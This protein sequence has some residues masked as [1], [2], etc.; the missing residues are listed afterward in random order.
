MQAAEPWGGG[1]LY[2]TPAGLPGRSAWVPPPPACWGLRSATAPPSP[3]TGHFLQSQCHP[4]RTQSRNVPHGAGFSADGGSRRQHAWLL[5]QGRPVLLPS[6][7][8][9]GLTGRSG[10]AEP[11][12]PFPFQA[13]YPTAP[14]P[15][16]RPHYTVFS[17]GRTEH[18][19]CL[20]MWLM[21]PWALTLATKHWHREAK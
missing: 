19:V 11:S 3:G 13:F 4:P 2:S 21:F 8:L 16:R 5:G 7:A 14:K 17:G 12:I 20:C 18:G 1:A 6:W 10:A 9:K 15:N